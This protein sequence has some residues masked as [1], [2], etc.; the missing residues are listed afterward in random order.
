MEQAGD[1]LAAMASGAEAASSSLGE[2]GDA[3]EEAGTEAEGAEGGFAGLAESMLA[4]GEALVITEGLKEF[5]EEALNAY[6]TVQSV[7]IGLTQLTGSAEQAETII[8]QIKELAATEPFAFPDIAPTVQKMVAL[9]VAADQIPGVMQAVADAAAATGNQFNQVA[10]SFDR[11]T[12]SGTVNARALVQLGISTQGLGDVMGVASDQVKAAFLAM[13]Q[14]DRIETLEAAMGK[15]AG[16]A[17]AQAAGIKGAWQIFEN[18]FEEVMV[19]VGEALAPAAVAILNFGKTA[20]ASIQEA[21][22]AFN[23]LSEPVKEFAGFVAIA[24]AALVPLTGVVAALGFAISGLQTAGV[25]FSG[26]L[27]TVGIAGGEAAAGVEGAEVAATGLGGA[28]GSLIPVA[29]AVAGALAFAW[30]TGTVDAFENFGTA[31]KN[32]AA[33]FDIVGASAGSLSGAFSPLTLALQLVDTSIGSLISKAGGWETFWVGFKIAVNPAAD[34]LNAMAAVMTLFSGKISTMDPLMASM[35][36]KF[37]AVPPATDGATDGTNKFSAGLQKVVDAQLKANTEVAAAKQTLDDAGAALAA[38]TITQ[39]TYNAALLAYDNALQKANPHGKDFAST[40]AGIEAAAAKAQATFKSSLSV[41]DQLVIGFQNGSVSA[42]VLDEAYT[43]LE[44]S[45]KKAGQAIADATGILAQWQQQNAQTQ[46]VSTAT[47]DALDELTK[48]FNDGD[49]SIQQYTSDYAKWQAAQKAAGDVAVTVEGQVAALTNTVALQQGTLAVNIVAWGQLA[50]AA[51]TN[52]KD[53]PAAADA[54]KLVQSEASALG[55]TITQVGQGYTLSST[56]MT[57][58]GQASVK[59]LAEQMTQAGLTVQTI[60]GGIPVYTDAA[61]GV[62]VY[63]KALSSTTGNLED[64]N[65]GIIR[66]NVNLP[67][68]AA[69]LQA[70]AVAAGQHAVALGGLNTAALNVDPSLFNVTAAVNNLTTAGKGSVN[71]FEN[72]LSVFNNLASQTNLTVQQQVALENAFKQVQ[73]AG[74]ALGL[75]V[76]FVNGQLVVTTQSG[77]GGS[78]ALQGFLQQINNLTNQ[79]PASTAAQ[80]ALARAI[81]NVGAAAQQANSDIGSFAQDEAALMGG[82]GGGKGGG[83]TTENAAEMFGLEADSEIGGGAITSQ[84]AGAAGYILTGNNQLESIANWNAQ[85][86][87]QVADLAAAIGTTGKYIEQV[88]SYTDQFG[89][90]IDFAQQVL[91]TNYVPATTAAATST[92]TLATASTTAAS[93]VGDLATAATLTQ[94]QLDALNQTTTDGTTTTN[95]FTQ[96]IDNGTQQLSAFVDS[97]GEWQVT[98]GENLQSI[99]TATIPTVQQLESLG[100]S[101]TDALNAVNGWTELVNQSSAAA[102]SATNA[103]ANLASAASTAAQAL[104]SLPNAVAQV[105]GPGSSAGASTSSNSPDFVPLSQSSTAPA[106]PAPGET[107]TKG[108]AY[109]NGVL[110]PGWTLSETG[111]VANAGAGSFNVSESAAGA[112]F[113]SITNPTTGIST[114]IGNDQAASIINAIN[115]IPGGTNG[116]SGESEAQAALQALASSSQIGGSLFPGTPTLGSPSPQLTM[117]NSGNNTNTITINLNTGTVVGQNGAQQLAQMIQTAITQTLRQNAGLKLS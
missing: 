90:V 24:V 34:A 37:Q 40:V 113:G 51:L 84:E 93:S 38:G 109:V 49:I 76:Q 63:G 9:G 108:S 116:V 102:G 6:G 26:I 20:L 50:T 107:Y 10:N 53:L 114:S 16:S 13:D 21:V 105:S 104:Q 57:A 22:D 28:F 36:Q 117:T 87:V 64:V 115:S 45:A 61:T 103:T 85:V 59:A 2:T 27:T 71:T 72:A 66:L 101:S 74:T 97:M 82:S 80:D 35:L 29:A 78:Q 98:N 25:A 54:M 86:A 43:K 88:G 18:Q 17:E 7:T 81:N 65:T 8:N 60:S 91:N 3:A 56:N 14:S 89:N 79:T 41:Y 5:G 106:S 30:L 67:G 47:T 112:E 95:S 44:A 15:F 58:A 11:M 1:G 77:N 46:A 111:G 12:L 55:I 32:L 92:S 31:A 99:T 52:S 23:S 33:T 94:Q 39:G 83:S 75:Q 96:S 70:A 73:S 69:A 48:K 4:V 42:A 19:G 110:V 68:H 100:V 62:T